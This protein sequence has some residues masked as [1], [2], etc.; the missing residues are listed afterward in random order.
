MIQLFELGSV[1]HEFYLINLKLGNSKLINS[2]SNSNNF[3]PKLTYKEDVPDTRIMLTFIYQTG[4]FTKMWLIMK[5]LIFPVVL[6][7]MCWFWNRISQLDRVSSLLEQMLFSLGIS[8]T[9]LN[10]PV[11]WLTLWFDCQWMLLYTD[12]RQGIII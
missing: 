3:V 9:L 6:F 2:F 7:V 12:L 11:E 8:L 1:H 10:L 4:G 5:T